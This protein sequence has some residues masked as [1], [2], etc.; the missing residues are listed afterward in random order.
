MIQVFAA[1]SAEGVL[2]PQV[3]AALVKSTPPVVPPVVQMGGVE[4]EAKVASLALPETSWTVVPV[5]SWKSYCAIK[6]VVTSDG[7][8]A[9]Q[10]VVEVV[11]LS[12]QMTPLLKLSVE[13]WVSAVF[14]LSTVT[15][16]VVSDEGGGE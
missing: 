4:Q 10:S 5:P 8:A 7:T 2:M 3:F 9:V 16:A 12:A 1:L 15:Y 6:P 11:E 13:R 14:A